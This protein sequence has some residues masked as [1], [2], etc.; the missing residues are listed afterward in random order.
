MKQEQDYTLEQIIEQSFDF[1]DY[2]ADE[3]TELI[4]ET[5]AMIMEAALLRSLDEAGSEMQDTFNTFIEAE[6]TEEKMT[7]FIKNNLPGFGAIVVDEIKVFQEMGKND[8]D[9]KSE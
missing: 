7:D 1:S 8:T 5:S 3:K 2:S 6:P 4:A 9:T